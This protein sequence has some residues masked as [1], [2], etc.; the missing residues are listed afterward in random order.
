M[1]SERD[2]VDS[3]GL[4]WWASRQA[5]LAVLLSILTVLVCY[6]A[7]ARSGVLGLGGTTSGDTARGMWAQ[8]CPVRE[9]PPVANVAPGGLSEL[10]AQLRQIVLGPMYRRL[11]RLGTVTSENAWSDNFP[12][13]GITLLPQVPAAYERRWWTTRTDLVDDVFVFNSARE[14]RDFFEL[15]SSARCRPD[16]AQATTSSPPGGRDLVWRNLDDVFEE[17]V[18]LLRGVRVYRVGV[19]LDQ[20]G[21]GQ[22]NADRH[23]GFVIADGLACALPQA[24]CPDP[25]QQ[26][27][28]A[29]TSL[30]GR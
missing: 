7:L 17:D 25:A 26:R 30:A 12:Q 11:Y 10:R 24:D 6:L 19:V 8:G 13:E 2:G 23:T 29:L 3:G 1:T 20:S 28:L 22:D 21:G 18:Y 27:R 15:A 9:A 4:P 14:A 5:R 16:G